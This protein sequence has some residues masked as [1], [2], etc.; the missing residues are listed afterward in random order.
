MNLKDI[1][2]RG[3]WTAQLVKLLTVDFYSGHDLTVCGF[4]PE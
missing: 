3:D 1:I 2:R 4:G